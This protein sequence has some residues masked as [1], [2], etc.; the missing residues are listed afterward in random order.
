L[1]SLGWQPKFSLKKGLAA[2]YQWY[3]ENY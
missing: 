3:L 2:T 1:T